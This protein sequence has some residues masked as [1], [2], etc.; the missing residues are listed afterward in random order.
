VLDKG[1][2]DRVT[3]NGE[4]LRRHADMRARW[5]NLRDRIAR[6]DAELEGA[7]KALLDMDREPSENGSTLSRATTKSKNGTS[8]TFTSTASTISRSMSPFRKLAARMT[9]GRTTGR[10]TPVASPPRTP[11]VDTAVKEKRSSFFAFRSGRPSEHA[12]QPVQISGPKALVDSTKGNETGGTVKPKWNSSTKVEIGEPLD[13]ATIKQTPRRPSSRASQLGGN[14]P[15]LSSSL[16]GSLAYPRNASRLSHRSGMEPPQ[17]P[18]ASPRNRPQTPSQ[19]PLPTMRSSNSEGSQTSDDDQPEFPSSLMQRALSPAPSSTGAGSSPSH[20]KRRGSISFIPV[21]TLRLT[22]SRAASPAFSNYRPVSPALSASSSG[23]RSQT[24]ELAVRARAE[25]VP[26]YQSTTPAR[27][28]VRPH[29]NPPPSSFKDAFSFESR[30]SSRPSSRA[31][32]YDRAGAFTPSLEQ[33]PVQQYIPSSKDPLDV[34][35]ARVVNGMAHGFL[36]ERLDPPLRTTPPPGAEIK[37]QYA[38]S[39]ALSR[40]VVTCRLVVISRS[41]SRFRGETEARKVMCRVGGGWL[42]LHIY[43]LNHQTTA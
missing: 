37:A 36:I 31:T 6:I 24:P 28:G 42:D 30:P 14:V 9:G 20:G 33:N 1:V 25:Q 2:R 29:Q 32:N 38:I 35:V 43:L 34:E 13:V 11:G 41:G 23:F 16:A 19:I 39:N 10:A 5:R 18:F 7:R 15:N 12:S 17:L 4:C 22:G 8:R 27:P 3:K 40:K 26:F 21:P